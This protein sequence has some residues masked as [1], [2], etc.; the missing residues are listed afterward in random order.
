MTFPS[1]YPDQRAVTDYLTQERD[2][3]VEFVVTRPPRANLPYELDA[4]GATY[5]SG[6][7]QSGTRSLVF[8]VYSETGGAHP[9]HF[10][11]AFNYD[12]GTAVP[13]TFDTLFKP[14]TAPLDVVYPAVVSRLN[15]RFPDEQMYGGH[16]VKTYQDFAITDEA[17]IF[18]FDQGEVLSQVAG[19]IEIS[20]PRSELASILA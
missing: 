12:L 11:K 9:I 6:S 3:F 10:Y 7:P 8:S 13:I 18:F 5:E 2:S 15:K 17:V 4:K 20:V 14:G 1:G 19:P 16:D